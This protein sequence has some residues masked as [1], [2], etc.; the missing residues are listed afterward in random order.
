MRNHPTLLIA[1][2]AFVTLASRISLALADGPTPYPD[3]KNEV[4]W[5]GKGPIRM[6]GWM[7]DNRN[8]FW[9][10]KEKDQKAVVFVG[11]SLIGGYKVGT[12][13]PGLKV[14]NRGIGGETTRCLLFRIKEDVID[15]H[16]RAV[17]IC[18]GSNDLSCRADPA[19]AVGNLSVVIKELREANEKLPIILCL[20]TP[21]DVPD[22]PIEPGSL[23]RLNAG[24]QKLAA[25][26]RDI[27][28]VDTFTPLAT[29]DGQ[30]APEYFGSDRIHPTTAGYE[31]W[32]ELLAEAFER[33]G[34]K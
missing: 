12:A 29:P 21:R 25:G 10:Q 22:A 33:L 13:F 6:G 32:T 4:A 16:P 23:D 9:T 34:I 2:L 8:Y 7:Q 18:S 17:V 28:V 14:A 27:V 24:I 19:L 3:A 11:D 31:K 15:L 5:P 30:P 26:R 1:G 20:V